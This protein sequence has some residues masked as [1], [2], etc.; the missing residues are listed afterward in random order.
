MKEGWA[1][2]TGADA[3]LKGLRESFPGVGAGRDMHEALIF[4]GNDARGL[5][6]RADGLRPAEELLSLISAVSVPPD[7]TNR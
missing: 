1:L 2:I 5:R 7:S 3:R 4:I 6:V